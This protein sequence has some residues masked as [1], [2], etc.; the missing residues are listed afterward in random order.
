MLFECLDALA[1]RRR[2]DPQDCG[3]SV[4]RAFVQDR[5]ESPQLGE[6][7]VHMKQL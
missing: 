1:H 5:C 6:V 7:D 2:R 3:G 4:E